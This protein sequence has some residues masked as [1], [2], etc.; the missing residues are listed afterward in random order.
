[1]SEREFVST[2]VAKIQPSDYNDQYSK[3]SIQWLEWRAQLDNVHIQHALNEGEKTI[4]G[5]GYKLDGYCRETNT[6][7]E[8]HGCIFHGCP[9]CFSDSR[10]ETY[11][12]LTHQSLNELYALTL[13]KKAHLENLGMKYICIWDHDFKKQQNQNPE[14][15]QFIS[16]LEI[17]DR[18]D[19]RDSFFGSRT[20][21][22]QLYY[23]VKENERVKYVDFTTLYP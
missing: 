7:Y 11:H 10:E 19:P 21:A 4:P 3:A 12:P 1:M 5:T 20:N 15:R 23:K 16:H 22:S 18:L 6:A 8:Y 2:P 13:K 17:M 9:V 14:L